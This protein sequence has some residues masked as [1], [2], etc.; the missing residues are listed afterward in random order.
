MKQLIS[1]DLFAVDKLRYLLR[2][3]QG[4]VFNFLPLHVQ[5]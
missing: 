4:T 1:G 2:D 3:L 5:A